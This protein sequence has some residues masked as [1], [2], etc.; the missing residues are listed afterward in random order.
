VKEQ[1]IKSAIWIAIETI[2][3][4][5]VSFVS[6]L[7]LAR[8]LA[9]EDYGAITLILGVFLAIPGVLLNE[10]LSDMIVQREDLSDEHINAAF[11]INLAMAL[12][13]VAIAQVGAPLIA[14][15]TKRP[16]TESLFRWL[17][18]TLIFTALSAIASAMYRRDLHYRRFAARTVASMLCASIVAIAMALMGYGVWSLVGLQLTISGIG[19]IILWA[20]IEWRPKLP[21]SRQAVKDIYHFVSRLTISNTVRFAAEKVDTFIIG[22]FLDT[23]SLGFY[24]I[25]LRLMMIVDLI[26]LDPVHELMLPVLSR[27]QNDPTR[28]RR[29][30]FRMIWTIA[31]CYTP[32][33]AGLGV[34]S[35]LLFPLFFGPKWDGAIPL[36]IIC[37]ILCFSTPLNRPVQQVLV[38]L[39][40]PGALFRFNLIRLIFTVGSFLV[41]VQFG[42]IGAVWAL[43]FCSTV[44][45]PFSLNLLWR[46]A[47]ID[48]YEIA[49]KVIPVFFAVA[50]TVLVIWLSRDVVRNL[51][52][53]QSLLAHIV[54]SL[55]TYAVLLFAVARGDLVRFLSDIY[56]FVQSKMDA[57]AT[58]EGM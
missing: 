53:W 51:Q 35:P 17:S 52:P 1:A 42:I 44:F 33:L 43:V 5:A 20:G 23:V 55:V 30:Y 19:S 3:G 6:F 2:S 27:S 4:K 49:R 15:Y 29:Q 28:M 56:M 34:F 31:A 9:P 50:V 13:F 37:S 40:R 10:G 24:Y 39:G 57:K 36:M 54:I 38:S 26:A 41:G 46:F 21:V 32:L 18:V 48:P 11:W 7:I 16:I 58:S 12:V 14:W 25:V 8:L 47:G 45:V 22:L